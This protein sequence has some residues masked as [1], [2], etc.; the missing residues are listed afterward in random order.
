MIKIL[1][2]C[3]GNICR[4]PMAEAIFRHMIN[5]NNWND[6]VHCSSAATSNEEIGNRPHRGTRE[7]LDKYNIGYEGI[8]STKLTKE[9]G[10]EYDYIIGMDEA[11]IRNIRKITGRKDDKVKR[12]LEYANIN[13]DV[14][15]PWYTGDFNETYNDIKLGLD[16]LVS[17]LE[18]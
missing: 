9:M 13:R 10:K 8:T 6:F 5:V 11:N 3:H 14:R 1:F 4:S 15:D 18:L 2:V 16:G 17:E 12:I 7:I